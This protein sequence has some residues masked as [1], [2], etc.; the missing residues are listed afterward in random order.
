MEFRLIS[1]PQDRNI[2]LIEM[3]NIEHFSNGDYLRIGERHFS[4]LMHTQASIP[5]FGI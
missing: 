1:C 2:V 3:V 4:H 5:F